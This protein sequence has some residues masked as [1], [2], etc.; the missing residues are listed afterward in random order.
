MFITITGEL[1]SG[2]STVASILR[3]TYGFEIHSTGTVQREIAKD[4]GM[5]T[6]ELNKYMAENL[7]NDYDKLI[8]N[9]TIQISQELK[10]QKIVFDS[11]MA[12]HFVEDSLK[13]FVIVDKFTAAER[14]IG[15][16]RGNEEKYNSFEEAVN[17]LQE[18]KAIEDKRFQEMYQANTTDFNNFDFIIDSTDLTPEEIAKEIYNKATAKKKADQDIRISP[19]RLYPTKKINALCLTSSNAHPSEENNAPGSEIEVIFVN[20]HFFIV[21]GHHQCCTE[22]HNKNKLVHVKL[23]S[24]N[25]GIIAKYNQPISDLFKRDI[26]TYHQ[27]E[28]HNHITFREYPEHTLI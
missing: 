28:N 26:D 5:T 19:K 1:G 10:G 25:N 2:K 18:R 9:K 12:W 4:M 27:W 22:I 23:L 13:V 7:D 17:A 20:K 8:D 21:N 24:V 11:R 3:D 15:A 14:V 6:L 16:D